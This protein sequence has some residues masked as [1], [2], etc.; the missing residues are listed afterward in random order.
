MLDSSRSRACAA[1]NTDAAA[2]GV[3]LV[4]ANL[5]NHRHQ[6][7]AR[8]IDHASRALR[9]KLIE[10]AALNEVKQVPPAM[11]RMRPYGSSDGTFTVY[12]A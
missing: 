9:M 7:L 2:A 8:S 3:S 10:Q 4:R 1:E 5:P 6:R 11:L 12:S